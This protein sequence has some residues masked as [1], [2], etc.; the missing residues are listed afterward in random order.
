MK[1][2][3]RAWITFSAVLLGGLAL[4]AWK[5]PAGYLLN[6]IGDITQTILPMVLT[7]VLAVNAFRSTGRARAFWALAAGGAGLWAIA[8][9]LWT[10]YEVFLRKPVPMPFIG[11]VLFFLHIVPFTAAITV[12]PHRAASNDRMQ[13]GGIDFLMLLTWWVY[14]YLFLVIPWQYVAADKA[15]YAF[16]FNVLYT[17]E[18][19]ILVAG[20]AFLSRRTMSHGWRSVYSHLFGASALYLV[21]SQLVNHAIT[22]DVYHTGSAYDLPL[23]AAMCWFV[24]TALYA[25]QLR[26][27][28][29]EGAGT[30]WH[31]MVIARFAMLA[32]LSMPVIGAIGVFVHRPANHLIVVFRLCVTLGGMFMLPLLLFI[33]QHLL[34][35]ELVRLLRASEH[36]L[37]MQKQL[38]AQLVQSEK[39]S[40]LAYLVAG[41]AHEINNPLTA[42]LGY[43]DLL[44]RDASLMPHARQFSTKIGE[45]ARRTREL[46]SDLLK[47][48]RQ[49]P[50]SKVK[51]D[52]NSI[53]ANAVELR[54]LDDHTGITIRQQLDPTLPR[55]SADPNQMLQVCFHIIGNAAEA[56]TTVGGG[57]IYIRTGR[58]NG[59][60][61]LEFRDTG[62]GVKDASK[63]F[64]PFYTTKPV[65]QGTGLG[66]SAVYGIIREHGGLIT[67]ENVESGAVFKILLPLSADGAPVPDSSAALAMSAASGC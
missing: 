67:C 48:G 20:C 37:T 43:S 19:A 5:I 32:T 27:K 56:L 34:D 16:N 46:V 31:A 15:A 4:C 17:I 14:L 33:K 21:G 57:T 54:S 61:V 50:A 18:N 47:F 26:L 42:I 66:L 3:L 1:L 25:Q 53:V 13:V 40:S 35:R 59:S 10:H 52:L 11:D 60:A 22:R 58:Q 63:I 8:N 49:V 7:A 28:P 24:A 45:Q 6:S 64:D 36:S 38:Q 12:R 2:A 55:I 23:I 30:K 29:Q 62:P 9:G 44:Q 41:A 65:G 51:M 39:L